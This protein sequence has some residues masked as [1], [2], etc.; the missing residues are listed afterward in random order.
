MP[1]HTSAAAPVPPDAELVAA[2]LGGDRDA[3]RVI[4]ER[5]QRLL[6]SL[7][8]SATGRLAESE[9]LAQEAFVTAWKQLPSLREPHRLRPWLCTIL[10]HRVGRLRRKEIREPWHGQAVDASEASVAAPDEPVPTTTMKAEEQALLWDLLEQLP[11]KYREP[12]V[13]YYREHQ[14]AESVAAALDLTPENARQRLARGRQMLQ[15]S[16]ARFVEG[17]LTRTTPGAT[18]TA[19][20]M[21]VVAVT[22]PS[23]KAAT[24]GSVT[25]PIAAGLSSFSLAALLASVSGFFSTL[26][27]VRVG[28]D[29]ANTRAERIATVRIAVILAGLAI[30]VP[31]IVY[32]LFKVALAAPDL[33]LTTVVAAQLVTAAYIVVYPLAVLGCLRGSRQLRSRERLRDPAAFAHQ[34]PVRDIRSRWTLFG[35]PLVHIRIGAPEAGAP[36]VVAWIAGGDRAYGVL[37]AWG[38]FAVGFISVGAFASGVIAF[39]ALGIGVIGTGTIGVGV[40]GLGA[41][42]VGYQAWSSLSSLGLKTAH[43]FGFAVAGDAAQA[44]IALAPHAN[45]AVAAEML[46]LPQADLLTITFLV[47]AAILA[48][49]PTALYAQAVRRRHADARSG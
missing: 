36:P 18:F 22:A 28:L 1:A 7:A 23:A 33:T 32:G 35:L 3:F 24:I 20:V 37:I 42:G 25:G 45:D 6:C 14:S 10:R 8:Y 34:K 15:G 40:V 27:A 29:Q 11:A 47:L 46:T 48:M 16:V 31:G 44:Q 13:L 30:A 38:A 2:A 43:S 4:V 41:I 17:A 49:L 9:D 19:A 26:L 12:L 5:Y 21:A 39:G